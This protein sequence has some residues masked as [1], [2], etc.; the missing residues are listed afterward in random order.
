MNR[1][2]IGY[3]SS[4]LS[5]PLWLESLLL[6]CGLPSRDPASSLFLDWLLDLD[7]DSLVSFLLTFRGGL[8]D[9][10][11]DLEALSFL[12]SLEA[13]LDLDLFSSCWLLERLSF[14][15]DVCPRSLD[16]DRDL[17]LRDV[18]SRERLLELDRDLLL[19]SLSFDRLRDLKSKLI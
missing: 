16:L 4:P 19:L 15:S 7:L 6:C 12:L 2:Q 10:D 18:L 14:T 17:S 1:F 5:P 9:R 13:L 8:R 3:F 11:L